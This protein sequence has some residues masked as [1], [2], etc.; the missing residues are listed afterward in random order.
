M[1]I[2]T[3]VICFIFISFYQCFAQAS[4]EYI[5]AIKLNDTSVITYR[6]KFKAQRGIID[7]FSITDF[8]GEHE[9]KSIIKGTYDAHKKVIAF[10]ETQIVYTKSPVSQNDFCNVYFMPTAFKLG[11]T[12][13]FTGKFKGKFSDGTECINGEIFLNSVENVNK[14][15]AKVSKKVKKSKKINDTIKDKLN[16]LKIL[17]KVNLNVLKKNQVTSV[18]TNSEKVTLYIYDGGK[19]DGDRITIKN[20]NNVILSKYKITQHKKSIVLSL[21]SKKT[22]LTILSESI[23]TIGSN[24]AVIEYVDNAQTIKTLTNLQKGETTQIDILRR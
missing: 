1:K 15:I 11:K 13:Y 3:L 19:L 22:T 14:R 9:T 16:T 6:I 24:T 20:G 2:Y 7:G 23:G 5:G 10:N 12:K 4:N 8:G 17:D 18:F 21:T